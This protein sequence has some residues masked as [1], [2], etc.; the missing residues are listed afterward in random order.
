CTAGGQA[1]LAGATLL[2]MG[3]VNVVN[4]GSFQA[5]KDAGGPVEDV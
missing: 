5:W 1:A 3:Y 4:L 2:D